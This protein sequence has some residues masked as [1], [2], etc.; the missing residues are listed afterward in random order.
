[1]ALHHTLPIY[2]AA[3]DL[4][5]L[6]VDLTRNIPR[7]FNRQLGDVMRDE[8]VQMMVLIFRANV[9]THKTAHIE[10]L[11]E[12]LEVVNLLLRVFVDKRFISKPQYAQAVALTGSIGKQAGGWRKHSA[13]LPDSVPSRRT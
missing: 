5:G 9:A 1:M 3:Y 13:A 11:L 8:C 4:L 7:D 10:E 2:K 6:S 12:R